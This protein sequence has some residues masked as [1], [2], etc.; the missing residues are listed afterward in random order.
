MY[1]FEEFCNYVKENIGDYLPDFDIESIELKDITKNNGIILKGLVILENDDKC[2]GT[3]IY[4]QNFYKKFKSGRDI[5]NSMADIAEAY[6]EY[7][8]NIGIIKKDETLN[9]KPNIDMIIPRLINYEKNKELLSDCPHIK[10]QDLAITFRVVLHSDEKNFMSCIIKDSLFDELNITVED[11]YKKALSN[12]ERMFPSYI[13]N[14]W[15]LLSDMGKDI[16]FIP[17]NG[18]QMYVLTN[19]RQVNGAT[20]ILLDSVRESIAEIF[21]ENVFILPSSVHE[22]IILKESDVDDVSILEKMVY[23]VNRTS[24]SDVEFLSDT[25]YH[26]DITKRK[27]SMVN[28]PESI[29]KERDELAKH[30][31]ILDDMKYIPADKIR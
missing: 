3:T 28:P 31:K 21:D 15:D 30:E 6:R 4:L 17:T 10:F 27:I 11:L 2:V 12:Y 23:D 1:S 26:Y 20:S 29:I 9:G 16:P 7:R 19:D 22:F 24:L 13:K 14:M 25:I 5:M 18:P 8:K